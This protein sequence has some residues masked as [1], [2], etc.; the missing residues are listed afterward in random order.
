[1]QIKGEE[2]KTN[3]FNNNSNELIIFLTGWGCDDIQ[4][5][6]MTSI[7]KKYDILICWNYSDLKFEPKLNFEKYS[8]IYLLTY[9][10]GVYAAGLIQNYLPKIDYSIAIN[11]NPLMFDKLFGIP[12]EVLNIFRNLNLSNYIDFRRKY[13]VYSEDELEFFNKH[14]SVRDFEDCNIELN[15]LEE[16]SRTDYKP[17][18]F[19]KAILSDSDRIFNF[20]TQKEYF[21][22][23]Y[24]ELKDSAHNVFFK[25]QTFESIIESFV[26]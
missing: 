3:Y 15:K 10:A 14:S 4:F 17:Y 9:S 20:E 25:F 2:M 1:M 26:D 18:E 22:N 5:K 6:N 21:K 8:K 24:Y 23:K 13:L 7:C 11:G 16:F 12:K 19:D